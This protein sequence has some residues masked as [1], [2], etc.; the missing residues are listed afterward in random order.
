M[1]PQTPHEDQGR[2]KDCGF[3]DGSQ[4]ITICTLHLSSISQ[5]H[6]ELLLTKP[7]IYSMF[8][9]DYFIDLKMLIESS[10]NKRHQE[11]K[12]LKLLI[13]KELYL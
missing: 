7:C 12:I 3:G 2:P 11:I 9:T 10:P 4:L 5:C 6:C 8:L 1:K 13:H